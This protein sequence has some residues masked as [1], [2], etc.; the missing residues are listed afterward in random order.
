MYVIRCVWYE[1]ISTP[2]LTYNFTDIVYTTIYYYWSFIIDLM[3]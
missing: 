3:Y 1:L 2:W